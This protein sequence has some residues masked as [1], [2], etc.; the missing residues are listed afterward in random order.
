MGGVEIWIEA[1]SLALFG[2]GLGLGL[3]VCLSS[4]LPRE[5]DTVNNSILIGLIGFTFVLLTFGAT[6]GLLGAQALN[7]GRLVSEVGAHFSDIHPK[8]VGLL[9]LII[10]RALSDALPGTGA[11]KSFVALSY[12]ITFLGFLVLTLTL[13][14]HSV[15]TTLRE[16]FAW[17]AFDT[18]VVTGA[19]GFI[20]TFILAGIPDWWWLDDLDGFSIRLAIPLAVLVECLAPGWMLG[21]FELSEYINRNSELKVGIFWEIAIKI[22][23]PTVLAFLI[24]NEVVLSRGFAVIQHPVWLFQACTL[25]CSWRCC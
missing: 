15:V 25:A 14:L 5:S 4:Y 22:F 2:C 1:Y 7:D 18:I 16:K 21:T 8:G 20:L 11:A 12:F 6:A 19:L 3:H 24:V 9:L 13:L 17:S 23:T 10:P